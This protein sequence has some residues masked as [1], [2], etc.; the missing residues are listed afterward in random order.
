MVFG[1]TFKSAASAPMGARPSEA[2]Q[3]NINNMLPIKPIKLIDG[4]MMPYD[5]PPIEGIQAWINSKP[6]QLNELKGKVVLIDFWA[7][8]CIN[9]VRTLPY[10]IDWYNKYQAQGLVVIGVHSPEFDFERDYNNVKKAVAEYGINYPVA[11]DN[12]FTTWQN[13]HN[14]YWPAHY[15][16]DKNGK[17]VYEHFGEGDYDITENN[18]RYLL[19]ITAEM[20]TQEKQEAEYI[21]EQTPETYLG[22]ERENEYH[23]KESIVKDHPNLYSY[24]EK[25]KLPSK[26]PSVLSQNAWALQGEWDIG[27]QKITATK[28]NASILLHFYAGKVFAVMGS[29]DNQPIQVRVL[30]NGVPVTAMSGK[31]VKDGMLVVNKHDLYSLLDLKR[32]TSGIIELIALEPG[33][34]IY[35]FT[36]GGS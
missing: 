14:N 32:N 25:A 7:Y 6:L 28:A 11:L 22:Y 19:G 5:A 17:V 33:L 27:A 29:Q 26:M 31:D 34:E 23:S 36:F 30:L 21:S 12:N 2:T 9:C 13:Y 20:K 4:L 8:S 1:P 16:I 18:I 35:T 15:L 3:Q 10:L 24:P